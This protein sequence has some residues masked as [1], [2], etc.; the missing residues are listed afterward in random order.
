MKQATGEQYRGILK[1]SVQ[2]AHSHIFGYSFSV[3]NKQEGADQIGQW[4]RFSGTY[5][6]IGRRILGATVAH[7]LKNETNAQRYFVLGTIIQ[8]LETVQHI[9]ATHR[10]PDDFPDVGIIEFDSSSIHIP[11]ALPL[12]RLRLDTPES[13][14]RHTIVVGTPAE[15][16][17]FE[18]IGNCILTTSPSC[19]YASPILSRES[20]P[21]VQADENVD[22]FLDYPEGTHKMLTTASDLSR[23]LP[24]PRGMSGGGIWDL[25]IN[26]SHV[27]SAE[28]C[29]L[30]GIQAAWHPKE[31]YLRGVKIYHWLKLVY[32]KYPDI[33]EEIDHHFPNRFREPNHEKMPSHSDPLPCTSPADARL[34]IPPSS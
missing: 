1:G 18:I 27:W 11:Q 17:K 9:N 13:P 30:I 14:G 26:E 32:E 15:E 19:G 7:P 25:N 12:R 6:Q 8:N 20:W 2:A 34:S 33:R 4:D 24:H 29:Q 16:V 31:R 28:A 22:I 21:K 5:V 3:Q 23:T 10:K